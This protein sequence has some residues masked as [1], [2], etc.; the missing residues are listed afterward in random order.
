[1]DPGYKTAIKYDS[2][3]EDN[4]GKIQECLN[5]QKNTKQ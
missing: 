1:M 5:I 2:D 4:L 3:D